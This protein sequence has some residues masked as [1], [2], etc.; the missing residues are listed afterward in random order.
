MPFQIIRNPMIEI[1]CLAR[2][3][4]DTFLI[5]CRRTDCHPCGP[6]L[7]AQRKAEKTRRIAFLLTPFNKIRTASLVWIVKSGRVL[8]L[9]I[10]SGLLYTV[11]A[12]YLQ[13]H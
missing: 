4:F 1:T 13:H 6:P 7:K 2:L 5:F 9:I 3:H 11:Y 12:I 8:I 10:S